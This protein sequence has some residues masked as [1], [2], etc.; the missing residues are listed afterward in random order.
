MKGCSLGPQGCPL[1]AP[2]MSSAPLV[3]L[4]RHCLQWKRSLT[5]RLTSLRL[6]RPRLMWGLA[7][8]PGKQVGLHT[9]PCVS[10][11]PR[12][13]G[14]RGP[15]VHNCRPNSTHPP[16]TPQRTGRSLSS[17]RPVLQAIPGAHALGGHT[18]QP[19]SAQCLAPSRL[20]SHVKN[21]R[22]QAGD[23]SPQRGVR[24]VGEETG[25]VGGRGAQQQ[26]PAF[27]QCSPGKAGG[28][29]RWR[30]WPGGW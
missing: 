25:G 4:S 11:L 26:D 1:W 28:P 5:S 12:R 19:L 3:V 22:V 27:P 7:G 14:H 30:G 20:H 29:W 2:T 15:S 10:G 18:G 24:A 23:V 21:A 9:D 13:E 6:L 8:L 17:H 16:M